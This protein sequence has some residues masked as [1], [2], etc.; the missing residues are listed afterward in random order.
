MPSLLFVTSAEATV[1]VT[2]IRDRESL[3]RALVNAT[4]G[5]LAQS[6]IL[7]NAMHGPDAT[8][9]AGPSGLAAI[10]AYPEKLTRERA[11]HCGSR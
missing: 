4:T 11:C 3:L 2:S 1:G 10:D 9:L 6:T 8:G 5:T 7:I